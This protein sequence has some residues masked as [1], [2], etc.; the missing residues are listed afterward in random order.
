MKK[1]YN[2]SPASFI[3]SLVLRLTFWYEAEKI[4][5]NWSAMLSHSLLLLQFA[6]CGYICDRVYVFCIFVAV[7]DARSAKDPT[8]VSREYAIRAA[9]LSL[10]L[11]MYLFFSVSLPSGISREPY[12]RRIRA[13]NHVWRRP[14]KY[15]RSLRCLCCRLLCASTRNKVDK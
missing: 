13:Q 15:T 11:T 3:F 10:S 8:R 12:T 1:E 14:H 9:S 6:V 7:C 4:S 5:G 2:F